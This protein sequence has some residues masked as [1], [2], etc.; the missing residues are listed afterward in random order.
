MERKVGSGDIVTESRVG[1]RAYARG[2]TYDQ[3]RYPTTP[4]HDPDDIAREQRELR[5]LEEEKKRNRKGKKNELPSTDATLET[6]AAETPMEAEIVSEEN[7][8]QE[9]MNPI[10]EA[11]DRSEE[12][13]QEIQDPAD[14]PE[15]EE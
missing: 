6:T 4:Y 7:S 9:T 1:I 15:I 2:R 5:E 8:D 11:E 10:D 12:A 13:G 14:I 3:D